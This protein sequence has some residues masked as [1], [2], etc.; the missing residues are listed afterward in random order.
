MMRLADDGATGSHAKFLPVT[1]EAAVKL[2]AMP[3]D[4]FVALGSPSEI[5]VTV[6]SGE[7]GVSFTPELGLPPA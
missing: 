6:E 1:D 2:F 7:S 3:R 4:E 5:T